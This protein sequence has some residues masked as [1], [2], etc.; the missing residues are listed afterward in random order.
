MHRHKS[1]SRQGQAADVQRGPGVDL[2]LS[3]PQTLVLEDDLG[4]AAGKYWCTVS[5]HLARPTGQGLTVYILC[6]WPR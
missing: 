2:D 4:S 3:D 1:D 6:T 5:F